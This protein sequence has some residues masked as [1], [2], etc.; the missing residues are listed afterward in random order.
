MAHEIRALGLRHPW[1]ATL[2]EGHPVLGPNTLRLLEFTLAALDGFGLS[3]GELLSL[4]GL[5]NGYVHG[6]VR[7]QIGWAEARRT[8][9]DRE[10]WMRDIR[11]Y[12]HSLIESGKCP[13]FARYVRE[14][15][16]PHMDPEAR[17]RYGLDRVLDGIAAS[18]PT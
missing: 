16:T 6:V 10:Q 4:V 18:L 15:R 9:V 12:M 5:L 7:N 3:I 11:P 2:T 1:P 14:T 8:K 13:M 17:F